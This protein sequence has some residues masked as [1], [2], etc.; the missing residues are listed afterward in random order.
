VA[1]YPGLP[2]LPPAQSGL[3]GLYERSPLN[4]LRE[5]MQGPMPTPAPSLMDQMRLWMFPPEGEPPYVRQQPGGPEI[6]EVKGRIP[7]IERRK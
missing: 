1:Q 5:E 6:E 4:R 3:W 7:M 2:F